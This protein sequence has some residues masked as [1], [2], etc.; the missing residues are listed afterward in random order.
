MKRAILLGL[1]LISGGAAA[2][3]AGPWYA[4]ATL[5]QVSSGLEEAYFETKLSPYAEQITSIAL[6]DSRL[7]YKL[8][9]GYQL[10]PYL[11]I[12]AG[13]LDLGD[14]ELEVAADVANRD[15][16]FNAAAA[17]HP[18]SAHGFTLGVKGQY[19]FADDWQLALSGGQFF[20]H[21]DYKSQWLETSTQVGDDKNNGHDWYYGVALEYQVS[22][23]WSVGIA[24]QRYN[25]DSAH[26]KMFGMNLRYQF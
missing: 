2:Q 1:G 18:Y 23:H 17:Y 11:A 12:E 14:V 15:V 7:G 10:K 8:A 16:F 13:Y 21:G 22:E 25:T 4:E 24:G 5:G 6:D 26:H 19:T 20:W 3:A 9:A